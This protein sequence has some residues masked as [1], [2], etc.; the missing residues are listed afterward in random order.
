MWLCKYC[1]LLDQ[2][3]EVTFTSYQVQSPKKDN[4][5]GIKIKWNFFFIYPI[6]AHIFIF[7]ILSLRVSCKIILYSMKF[8]IYLFG[9]FYFYWSLQVILA[10]DHFYPRATLHILWGLP[11]AAG[12]PLRSLYCHSLGLLY[13]LVESIVY[14]LNLLEYIFS[15]L[16][17]K[18]EGDYIFWVLAY[19]QMS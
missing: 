10:V 11:S 16:S 17:K 2:F 19:V 4:F 3:A 6:N 1:F 8:S 7:L 15:W 13:S 18:Y 5:A 9:I 14:F 12:F